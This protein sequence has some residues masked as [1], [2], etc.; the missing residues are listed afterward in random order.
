MA[1][2][3]QPAATAD[4]HY[5]PEFY[6]KGFTKDKTLWVYEKDKPPRSSKPKFEAHRENYY[7]FSDRGSPDDAAEKTLS[8]IE[9]TVAPFF[10][11]VG[12]LQFEIS[13]E[14]RGNLYVF[15]AM[16]F[17]RVPAYREFMDK[18]AAEMMRK[19]NTNLAGDRE[20]FY[21]SMRRAED[22][23]GES[24]GDYE[25]LRQF[26]LGG[27]TRSRRSQPGSICGQSSVLVSK[28][29]TY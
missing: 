5:I 28:L 22:R 1:T 3:A 7:I 21:E 15:V 29:S 14:Q 6:L 10:R 24:F 13:A 17:V 11:K 20:K 16:L 9:S 27:I 2:P 18:Q 12:N 26:I 25:K 19:Q 23:S 4:H 8:K